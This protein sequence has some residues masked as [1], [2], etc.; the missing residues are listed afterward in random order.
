MADATLG[1][2][3]RDE[4]EE[5]VAFEL[6]ALGQPLPQLLDVQLCLS[7]EL[8]DFVDG[9]HYELLSRSIT[10]NF[11]LGIGRVHLRIALLQS[12]RYLSRRL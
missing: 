9:L 5:V 8:E 3:V 6:R 10:L 12:L 11:L 1:L 4:L 2:R 7:Y